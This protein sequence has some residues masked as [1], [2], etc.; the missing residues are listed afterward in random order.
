MLSIP[1]LFTSIFQACGDKPEETG[2]PATLVPE[3][4]T[5]ASF[6]YECYYEDSLCSVD[7]TEV[8]LDDTQLSAYLDSEGQLTE[9]TCNTLCQT[10]SE[11]YYDYL[12]S[13]DYDGINTEGLH[14]ITCEYT[15]CA[16]EGR[17]HGNILK[18]PRPKKDGTS[19]FFAR[20]YHAEASSVA[21][22]LQLRRELALHNAPSELLD[23]CIKA[24]KE[25]IIHARFMAGLA[26]KTNPILPCLDFGSVLNRSL[27]ELALD[28]ATE[29]CIFESYAALKAHYQAN[30]AT[31]S[32]IKRLM[33]R[34]AKDETNHA[35][36]AWD[37]HHYLMKRL[38]A[39]EQKY[40]I[41][42]Q[43]EA[44]VQLQEQVL[45]E[46]EHPQRQAVGFPPTTLYV[47]F[48]A[49]I[50]EKIA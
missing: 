40:I 10:E 20:A 31:N 5:S 23:R 49:Q 3:I 12:C 47:H 6:V 41:Q 28:N 37:I 34:I 15:I 9:Q 7:S 4:N 39:E 19:H 26:K 27:F 48:A 50:G 18:S 16:V 46:S 45:R 17:G 38:S 2:E 29:G 42:A 30:N 13:C 36:L 35:Q 8:L 43:Q 24:A 44:L 14:P 22:F 1:L 25:E 21:A 32:K 33:Q 11:E